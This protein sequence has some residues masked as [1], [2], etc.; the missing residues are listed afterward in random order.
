MWWYQQEDKHFEVRLKLVINKLKVIKQLGLVT[1][2]RKFK[3]VRQQVIKQLRLV[4]VQ[5]IIKQL[6]VA[7]KK[8]NSFIKFYYLVNSNLFLNWIVLNFINETINWNIFGI[9][10][11]IYLR[12]IFSLVFDCVIISHKSFTWDLDNLSLFFIF[13]VWLLVRN[14]LNST[15]SFNRL[16]NGNSNLSWLL[17]NSNLWSNKLLNWNLLNSWLNNLLNSWLNNLLGSIGKLLGSI[18]LLNKTWL[19]ICKRLKFIYFQYSYS[20]WNTSSKWGSWD[21]GN[22][23]S[24]SRK[25]AHFNFMK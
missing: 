17:S 24:V 6:K 4:I 25:I 12:D 7:K 9:L 2:V 21:W 1:V 14:I 8:K 5:L 15:F 16:L 23:R 18:W 20:L 11:L 22:L 19:S 10:F 3:L 13:N